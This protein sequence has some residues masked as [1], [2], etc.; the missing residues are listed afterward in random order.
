MPPGVK[1]GLAR[2]SFTGV[3]EGSS[4]VSCICEPV[5]AKLQPQICSGTVP[6][7]P[8]LGPAYILWASKVGAICIYLEARKDMIISKTRFLGAR[9]L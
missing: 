5:S 4:G 6:G 1:G 7:G 3:A 9:S 8:K 2:C